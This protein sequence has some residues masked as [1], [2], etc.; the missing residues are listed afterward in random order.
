VNCQREVCSRPWTQCRN[1]LPRLLIGCAGWLGAS[2][3]SGILEQGAANSVALLRDRRDI[4][5]K[6]I[7]TVG[8]PSDA[9]LHF[10]FSV[11]P[12]AGRGGPSATDLMVRSG[13]S[14]LAIEAKWTE[15]RYDTV[16]KWLQ[17]GKVVANRQKVLAGWLTLLQPHA[18]CDLESEFGDCAYQLLHRAASACWQRSQ[19]Q[20]A[21]LTFQR[22]AEKEPNS[23]HFYRRDLEHLHELLGCPKKFPFH[24]FQLALNPTSAFDAIKAV[25][26]RR[27]DTPQRIRAALLGAPLFEFGDLHHHQIGGAE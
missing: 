19:P 26:K 8:L 12:L 27:A 17:S 6:I 9:N 24:H 20:L 18:T 1:K 15:A 23:S 2:R 4:L 3:V 13:A 7:T 5:A 11:R 14:G 21:Y 22:G 16:T 25:P 10:E